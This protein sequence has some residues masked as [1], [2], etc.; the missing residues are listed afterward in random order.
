MSLAK[1]K[2][3][4]FSRVHAGECPGV[5]IMLHPPSKRSRLPAPRWPQY[6]LRRLL[7]AMAMCGVV[8]WIMAAVGPAWSMILGWFLVMAIVHVAGT[9]SGTL[10]RQHHHHRFPDEGP[11][12][13]APRHLPTAASCAPSTHLR[14]P[15]RLGRKTILPSL[16]CAATAGA[17]ATWLLIVL[18]WDRAGYSG[19]LV[20]GC[21]AA[22]I[23]GLFG[24]LAS[25][26]VTVFWLAWHQACA[27]RPT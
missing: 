22:I 19:V 1:M 4:D 27:N 16:L 6:S 26:F 13:V 15:A 5:A 25:S 2:P 7:A 20:G 10:L 12:D 24:F 23:G 14:L 18:A 9:A 21:S 17:G 3:F 11:L 8:S